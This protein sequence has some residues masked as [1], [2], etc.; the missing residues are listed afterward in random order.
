M[1]G[2]GPG[3]GARRGH[4]RT[5]RA[6]PT[7][8]PRP[9][10]A[11]SASTARGSTSCSRQY[12]QGWTLDRM[13]A[14]DRTALRI[15]VFELL[16]VDDVPPRGGGHRGGRAGPQ[17]VHRRLAGVRQRRARQ[18]APRPRLPHPLGG[19]AEAG[20]GAILGAMADV[21]DQA[22][23]LGR[24]ADNSEWT[25]RAVRVGMVAY[26][27]VHLTIAWLGIQLA[28]G[29]H[30][31]ATSRNGALQQLVPAA[32][33]RARGVGRR[34]RAVPAGDLEAARGL[35]RPHREDGAKRVLQAADERLQGD[36]LRHARRHR[37]SVATGSRSKS[38]T[39]YTAKLM[40]Q[41]FGRWLVGLVGLAIIGVRRVPQSTA[42]GP[43]SSWRTSTPAGSQRRRRAGPTGC[44]ARSAT[45]P[46]ASRS[47]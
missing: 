6:R 20:S 28:L 35:R 4:R 14:V 5:A 33:R 37:R 29:D 2:A 38:S 47:A 21:S 13:P 36:R 42:A 8:T 19:S 10:S 15:G 30:S 11:G 45:S 3:R 12:S 7:P 44:S 23:Q 22:E 41:P 1:R 17:P 31:G 34:D 46:R 40:D 16:Y 26:G 43:R 24:R 18:H 9:W 32:V 27:I 25:D 39:D